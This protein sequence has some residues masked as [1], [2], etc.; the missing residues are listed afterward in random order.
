MTDRAYSSVARFGTVLG[1]APG[2][3]PAYSSDYDSADDTELPDRHA[4]RS[5]LDG[6]YLGQKWQCVEF[7]RRWLYV[8][9]GYIF[10][11]VAMAYEI[12]RLDSVRA[13][14]SNQRLPLRSFRNGSR[15]HPE[16]GGLLVWDEGGQFERT[17]HVAIITT[18]SAERI[19]FVEQNFDHQVWPAGQDFSRELRTSVGEAGEYWIECNYGD[20]AILGWVL[21]TDDHTHAEPREAV[22]PRLYDLHARRVADQGRSADAWLNTANADEAAYVRASGGHRLATTNPDQQRYFVLSESA[23]AALKHATNELHALFLHATDYVLRDDGLLER[24]NLPRALWPRIHQSWNN[25]R[26]QMITGRFDFS[27]SARGLK[28][29]EYNCDSASCH[30]ECGKIQGKWARHFHCNDGHDPGAGL[31]AALLRA[32]QRSDVDGVLH[33]MQDRHAEETYHALFMQEAIER[34]GLRSKILHGLEGLRF[35]P[36]GN[37]LDTDGERIRWVWKTWAWETALDQLRAECEDDAVLPDTLPARGVRPQTPRLVDVL[38][39]KD[40]MVYEP[41]WTLIPSN[42]AILP[43]LWQ[44]FPNHPNLLR[45]S[46]ELSDEIRQGGYV[47]KPIVGRCGANISMFNA[48]NGLLVE[49]DGRFDDRDVIHQAMFP[50]PH[51]AGYNVQVCTFTAAGAYAGSCVRVDASPIINEASDCMPLR[52]V[53]DGELIGDWI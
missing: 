46:Y 17:G 21:Q 45:T 10:D 6:I 16:P 41:L 24:F 47:S 40:V 22:D 32:W 37:V 39:R 3:V 44:L 36:H 48:E 8:N 15:R 2:G 20:A 23:E 5:Y 49:T 26:N 7:A 13:V 51:S 43:I 42:K 53:A 25:R 31:H 4:Y 27:L 28:L 29:Y 11:N 52:I 50:L 18:V 19:R 35:D 9:K 33:I 12:F 14:D 38:L 34:A 30:M 1:I